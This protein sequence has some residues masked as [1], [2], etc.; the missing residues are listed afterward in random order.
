MVSKCKE[1]RILEE[2]NERE[3]YKSS[4]KYITFVKLEINHNWVYA[5]T[6]C[7]GSLF[8]LFLVG[9]IWICFVLIHREEE[10]RI[11][12]IWLPPEKCGLTA[13]EMSTF[14]SK[15]KESWKK[16]SNCTDYL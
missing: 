5:L 13:V 7:Q 12:V 6:D 10:K 2:E 15:Y 4:L 9:I 14:F 1:T 8:H 3:M 16:K 11:K